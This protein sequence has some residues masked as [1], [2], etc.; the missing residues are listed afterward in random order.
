MIKCFCTKVSISKDT[1]KFCDLSVEDVTGLPV[2][3]D[4]NFSIKAT[5]D[6]ECAF[7]E[8]EYS[9]KENFGKS[10]RVFAHGKIIPGGEIKISKINCTFSPSAYHS[11]NMVELCELR[12]DPYS[13]ILYAVG[14][15]SFVRTHCKSHLQ[16]NGED[17]CPHAILRLFDHAQL[18]K[19]LFEKTIEFNPSE[20]KLVFEMESRVEIT[21]TI[22]SR[23]AGSLFVSMVQYPFSGFYDT[24]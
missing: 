16:P 19:D 12:I 4:L 7:S 23:V 2:D 22:R 5:I 20:T 11:S 15:H 14:K 10:L 17:M 13:K 6:G 3:S 21:L 18:F 1:K 8:T 24:L 9:F